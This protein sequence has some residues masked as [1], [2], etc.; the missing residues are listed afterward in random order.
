MSEKKPK[1]RSYEEIIIKRMKSKDSQKLERVVLGEGYLFRLNDKEV[2]CMTKTNKLVT[3]HEDEV[4]FKK[5][6]ADK[7]IRLIA[8]ILP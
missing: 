7:K 4:K 8:E 1:S 6:P 3:T 2:L 5:F